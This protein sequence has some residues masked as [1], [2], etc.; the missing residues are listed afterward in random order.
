M[1]VQD[2][3]EFGPLLTGGVGLLNKMKTALIICSNLVAVAAVAYATMSLEAQD[4]S[5][6]LILP[7]YATLN[8]KGAEKVD[9]KILINAIDELNSEYKHTESVYEKAL[10][11]RTSIVHILSITLVSEVA[12]LSIILIILFR[13][14]RMKEKPSTQPIA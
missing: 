3:S 4:F 8:I 14:I 9:K 5:L 11:E 13:K 1:A 7:K 12:L 6:K 2:W 10:K